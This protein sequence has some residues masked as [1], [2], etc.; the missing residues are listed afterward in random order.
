MNEKK[1]KKKTCTGSLLVNINVS[2]FESTAY[3][4]FPNLQHVFRWLSLQS[5]DRVTDEA[6]VS[7]NFEV[8]P[9]LSFIALKGTHFCIFNCLW[10]VRGFSS[11]I[12]RF[13]SLIDLKA[14]G[15]K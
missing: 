11:K 14:P 7:R 2:V 8:W 3:L 1:K 9:L 13:R 6:F 12:F 15:A 10:M 5:H 4:K